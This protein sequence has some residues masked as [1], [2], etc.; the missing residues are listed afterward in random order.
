MASSIKKKP[1]NLA[2]LCMSIVKKKE[3]EKQTMNKWQKRLRLCSKKF[4]EYFYHKLSLSRCTRLLALG[5]TEIIICT[6]L[7]I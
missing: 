2:G 7:V 1:A 6:F 5:Q 3:E 4:V